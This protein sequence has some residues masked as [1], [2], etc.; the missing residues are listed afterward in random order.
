M[1]VVA[2]GGLGMIGMRGTVRGQ[3][4]TAGGANFHAA[5]A[6]AA[7]DDSDGI[8]RPSQLPQNRFDSLMHGLVVVL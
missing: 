7:R 6:R 1:L 3:A 4:E 2:L 5:A 8:A